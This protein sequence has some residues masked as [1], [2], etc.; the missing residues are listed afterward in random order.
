[1][2]SRT[3]GAASLTPYPPGIVPGRGAS[4]YPDSPDSK[5]SRNRKGAKPRARVDRSSR[6]EEERFNVGPLP[7]RSTGGARNSTRRSRRDRQDRSVLAGLNDPV[8]NYPPPSFQEAMSSSP[9]LSIFP[10]TVTLGSTIVSPM[11]TFI[12]QQSSLNV[13]SIPDQ[14]V[15]TSRWAPQDVSQTDPESNS[16]SE[17]SLQII[18][19]V[20]IPT[21]HGLLTGPD[22]ETAVREDYRV[23]R[24]VEFPSPSTPV[25]D[26]PQVKAHFESRGRSHQR[27]P[28]LDLAKILD[29]PDTPR[30][31]TPSSPK[32]RFLSLSPL[33][34]IFPSKTP[35]AADRPQTAHPTPGASPYMQ[36]PKGSTFFRST[37]SLATS[38]FLRLPLSSSTSGGKSEKRRFFSKNKEKS[39]PIQS[40]EA[41]DSWEELSADD[42]QHET[43]A[44]SLLSVVEAAC[45][46][47]SP[48]VAASPTRSVS[49]TYGAQTT[50]AY[51][52][53]Q[54]SIVPTQSQALASSVTLVQPQSQ[55][56]PPPSVEPFPQCQ[57]PPA[58]PP[59]P[60]PSP[61]PVQENLANA[62]HP[63]SL[64]DRKVPFVQR[65]VKKK[66]TP[67]R[68]RIQVPI[69][70]P[71]DP[72]V[73]TVRTRLPQ[74][75][76]QPP[77]APL[78][79]LPR[80]SVTAHVARPSPLSQDAFSSPSPPQAHADS[81]FWAAVDTP[82]PS[83]PVKA[84]QNLP[85][86]PV[87]PNGPQAQAF[88]QP[89][90]PVTARSTS[91]APLPAEEGLA[92]GVPNMAR[93]TP[94]PPLVEQPA[95]FSRAPS[96]FV[97]EPY[98]PTRYHYSGR[99]LPRPP[100]RQRRNHID[101]AFAPNEAYSET[102]AAS[103]LSTCP[104]GLLIDL[105]DEPCSEQS[106]PESPAIVSDLLDLS[107]TSES[108]TITPV[109]VLAPTPVSA[110]LDSLAF[111][112]AFCST[113][114]L[115]PERQGRRMS[116]DTRPV[117]SELTDLDLLASQLAE[118]EERLR[119]GSN[120]D[121]S[122]SPVPPSSE[123]AGGR[124]R[125]GMGGEAPSSK[126]MKRLNTPSNEGL[127]S[128]NG[129]HG[130]RESSSVQLHQQYPI[131]H[132]LP[133][134]ISWR[135]GS[136]NLSSSNVVLDSAASAD[137]RDAV[138]E[139]NDGVYTNSTIEGLPTAT[140]SPNV[141][142]S[143]ASQ[144]QYPYRQW[145]WQH[146]PPRVY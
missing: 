55:L 62:I 21:D 144:C 70:V 10:S 26:Q 96:P 44:P 80:N 87:T 61:P 17:D 47:G 106:E 135:A 40:P 25:N 123:A 24:G 54:A 74:N 59:P 98:T 115:S 34:T 31:P 36:S 99:P 120:Y 114:S 35:S 140:P 22:L 104:E 79:I 33:R 89:P 94:T 50:E 1:M 95:V 32:R 20:S 67:T 7:P 19:T 75:V 29:D 16:D 142:N 116:P 134:R 42:V 82:L 125:G 145:Q 85:S 126:E 139:Y 131:Q 63:L 127:A 37:T 18:E 38:S 46:C 137:T 52:S 76:P 41:L 101:S 45:Q 72:V 119:D 8:P 39:K 5:G 13:S 68:P 71:L 143:S 124:G 30:T 141:L 108:S 4:S 107:P 2:S 132:H 117:Y 86:P 23:R 113:P 129:V 11:G 110:T 121:V 130:T 9:S 83:T 69:P 102:F 60:P 136:P 48:A 53:L 81:S 66:T 93:W 122:S 58:T 78:P 3:P 28:K 6:P 109:N 84:A 64:R 128:G 43:P 14:S 15:S 105:E 56:Q 146:L 51:R 111:T 133:T 92:C 112:P 73:T 118:D 103:N 12:P 57:P 49:F 97:E 27:P 91:P 77:P 65:P 88:T 100:G 138:G 90:A